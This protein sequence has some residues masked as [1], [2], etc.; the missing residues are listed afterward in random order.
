MLGWW[1]I[2]AVVQVIVAL[3][4]GGYAN[5]KGRDGAIWFLIGLVLGPVAFLPLYFFDPVKPS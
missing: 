5:D 1:I 4:V 2:A 3:F